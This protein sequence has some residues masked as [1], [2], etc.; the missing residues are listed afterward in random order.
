MVPELRKKIYITIAVFVL[1]RFLAHVPVPGVNVAALKTLFSKSQF[2]S[3]L[4]IFSG[5]TLINFSVMALGLGPYIN[6][7]IIIQLATMVFPKLEALSKE[8]ESGRMVINQY[9][10]LITLP[11]AIVQSFGMY[12]ILKNQNPP[13]I[14]NLSPILLVS[15]IAT[16]TAGTFILM[17]LGEIINEKGIGNGISLII[18]AGIVGRLPIAA[19]QA[20]TTLTPDKILSTLVFLVMAVLVI[21]G[22]VFVNE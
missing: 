9:I 15:F 17:W 14:G 11:L 7:S 8:G 12:A 20:I 4:D 13:I 6:A 16:I 19:W 3:L 21:A 22:I 1:F 10:R 2:L 18:F 5:G